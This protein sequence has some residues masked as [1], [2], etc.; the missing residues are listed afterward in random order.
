MTHTMRQQHWA[1]NW[2]L[3]KCHLWHSFGTVLL[4]RFKVTSEAL[5]KTDMDLMTVIHLFK[6]LRS[7]VESLQDQFDHFE[8]SAKN[9]PSVCQS[10]KDELQRVKKQKAFSN[11]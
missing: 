3:L 6:S 11:E 10:Y 8:R 1:Q 2:A 4:S 5:Q 7:W 9:V